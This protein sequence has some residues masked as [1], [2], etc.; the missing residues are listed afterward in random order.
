[1]STWTVTETTAEGIRIV[2]QGLDRET[3]QK[4]IDRPRYAA[5]IYRKHEVIER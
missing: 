1:M 5:G 4:V 3:A 2:A